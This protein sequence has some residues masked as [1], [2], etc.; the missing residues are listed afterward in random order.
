ME[1]EVVFRGGLGGGRLSAGGRGGGSGVRAWVGRMGGKR[2]GWRRRGSGGD[3]YTMS[4]LEMTSIPRNP[5]TES[6]SR[7]S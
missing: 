5:N 4:T 2:I 6:K 7:D 1:K 3:T